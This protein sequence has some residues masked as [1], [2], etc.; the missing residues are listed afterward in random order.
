LSLPGSELVARVTALSAQFVEPIAELAA[1]IAAVPAPTNDEAERA[2][3][4]ADK[5]TTLGHADVTVDHLSDVIGRLPGKDTAK[6]LLLAAHIDTV[7][8]RA[9]P[10]TVSRE[11][12]VLAAPGIGDNSVSVAAVAL[13][14]TALEQLGHELAVDVFITG[15]VGEE[16][17]GDLRGMRAVVDALPQLGGAIAVEGHSLGRIT[18]RAV[19]SRRLRVTVTGPGGHSWGDAGRPSAI[20]ATAKLIARLDDIALSRDPKTTLNVGLISGGISV[21]TI[22]PDASIVIDMRSTSA[23]H[24]TQLVTK[25]EQ[26]IDQVRSDQILVKVETV[27]DRP[28]GELP[29]DRGLVPIGIDVLRS[30]GIEATCDASSTDANIPISR[31]IPSMCIGL[32]S[33]GNVHRLD[34]YIRLRP[35][36]TGFAQLLLNTILATEAI[37]SGSLA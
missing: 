16:G 25:V 33:G 34:E 18:N 11:G 10:I 37:A 20:H 30:L 36:A 3:F 9:T 15:N 17:L 28:A 1:A 27:G 22:A 6:A 29:Q 26:E 13:I 32:T 14:G 24:L 2:R 19:G 8:P 31:G 4:V 21:N 5:L 12:D 23:D 7:F 35:L